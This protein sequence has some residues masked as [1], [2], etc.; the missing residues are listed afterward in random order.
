MRTIHQRGNATVS[1]VQIAEGGSNRHLRHLGKLPQRARRNAHFAAPC[2][3][4]REYRANPRPWAANIRPSTPAPSCA[5]NTLLANTLLA[6]LRVCHTTI[7]Y[8]L[9]CQNFSFLEI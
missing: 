4:H 6:C 9:C 1:P 3:G 5:G 2:R 8:L 7:A